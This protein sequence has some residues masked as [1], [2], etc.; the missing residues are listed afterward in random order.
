MALAQYVYD[1]LLAGIVEGVAG[2]QLG[3][4]GVP[5]LPLHPGPLVMVQDVFER[6]GPQFTDS[7]DDAR[8]VFAAIDG[9]IR[10]CDATISVTPI[11]STMATEMHTPRYCWVLMFMSGG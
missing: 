10:R 2:Q 1:L 11:N 3:D 8:G 4:G 9:A 6:H 5:L 7:D